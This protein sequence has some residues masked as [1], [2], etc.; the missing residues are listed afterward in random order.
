VASTWIDLQ[1]DGDVGTGTQPGQQAQPTGGIQGPDKLRWYGLI[2]PSVGGP[3]QFSPWSTSEGLSIALYS[4]KFTAT[5]TVITDDKVPWDD[6]ELG[7]MQNLNLSKF[8]AVYMDSG[9]R[10]VQTFEAIINPLPIRD[11]RAGSKP[12]SK[13]EAVKSLTDKDGYIVNYEDVPRN[14]APWQTPDK[15]GTLRSSSGLDQF[16]T[17]L[18]ARQKSTNLLIFLGYAN[19]MVDWTATFDFAKQTGTSTGSGGSLMSTGEGQGS[20]TP[21]KDDP[22]ANDSIT[23]TWGDAP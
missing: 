2:S 4:P 14:L 9:N 8:T 22:V 11:G 12:W 6:Y 10:P 13:R 1:R 18:V 19:W 5:G 15:K 21:L 7:F 3:I 23:T 20:F 17:W 16:S